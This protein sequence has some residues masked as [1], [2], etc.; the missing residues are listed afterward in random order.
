[1]F[2]QFERESMKENKHH[3]AGDNGSLFSSAT[4][5]A[6]RTHPAPQKSITCV[7]QYMQCRHFHTAVNIF[8]VVI[9]ALLYQIHLHFKAQQLH[10]N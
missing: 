10:I 7:I 4:S 9:V 1:M 5:Y 8:S 6:D 2:E 3:E